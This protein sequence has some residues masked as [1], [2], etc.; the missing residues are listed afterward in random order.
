[1]LKRYLA[2]VALG[3]GVLLVAFASNDNVDPRQI[4]VDIQNLRMEMMTKA[5]E[6]GQPITAAEL[7]A[8]V[9]KVADEAIAQ[10]SFDD[11]EAS[12]A[13]DWARVYQAANHD[14]KVLELVDRYIGTDPD[15][16]AKFDAQ[17]VA[18]DSYFSLGKYS[19]GL[20]FAMDMVPTT[21]AQF[22]N[23]AAYTIHRFIPNH[24]DLSREEALEVLDRL[25]AKH[26][27]S[28]ADER[29]TAALNNAGNMIVEHRVNTL[30]ALDRKDEGIQILNKAIDEAVDAAA[31]RSLTSLRARL[32]NVGGAPPEINVTHT[33]GEFE[34]FEALRGQ[35][36]LIDFFAHWCGPCIASF[37]SYRQ[38][39]AELKDQGLEVIA[40][41]R[42]YGYYGQE[43]PLEPEVEFERMKGF[44]NEHQLEWPVVFTDP[45]AYEAYGVTGIPTVVVVDADGVVRQYK[46]GF[47]ADAF[48]A[49]KEEIMQL[50]AAA[51][52]SN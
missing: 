47:S 11:I 8:A 37:P 49:F 50:L 6:T 21:G 25:Q 51:K 38:L 13:A 16:Q 14:D 48:A 34:S 36:V 4:L 46:I 41:T 28:G 33:I 9:K 24:P 22:S 5:R 3:A 43:R 44:M 1:M 10:V 39:Y 42:F 52:A 12:A 20:D 40:V 35:V 2:A 7:N 23:L 30:I 17:F 31:T 27:G 26:L 18:L 19:E 32:S 45:E 29:D 15:P